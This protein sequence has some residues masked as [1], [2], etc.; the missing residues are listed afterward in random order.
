MSTSRVPLHTGAGA[1]STLI[2]LVPW[3]GLEA[4]GLDEDAAASIGAACLFVLA[5]AA[6]LV[7]G[8]PFAQKEAHLTLFRET[9]RVPDYLR[10]FALYAFA[11]LALVAAL[12]AYHHAS[13]P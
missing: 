9:F 6:L 13:S 8:A 7:R 1:F 10:A 5:V 2:V 4:A 11:E 12:L 3:Q